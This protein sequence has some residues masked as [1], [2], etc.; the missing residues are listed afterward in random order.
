MTMERTV[1]AGLRALVSTPARTALV[2]ATLLVGAAA[3]FGLTLLVPPEQRT[4]AGIAPLTQLILSVMTPLAAACLTSDLRGFDGGSRSPAAESLPSRWTAA[5]VYGLLIGAYGAVIVALATMLP[6]GSRVTAGSSVA[7]PWAG[8]GP[9]VIGCLVV[10]LIPVGVGCAAGL[11]IAR[12][13]R[14]Q[15]ATVLVPLA[16][17]FVLA[18]LAPAGTTDWV[19]PLAAADHLLPGPM[20]ILNWAQWLVTAAVWVIVPNWIGT[21][22]LRRHAAAKLTEQ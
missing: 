13:R 15:L 6:I 5:G 14:A 20:S 1:G 4:F 3:A 8:A 18:R 10:Q 2:L 22:L 11:L 9:A 21:R 16:A 17:S 7:D 12:I 19:T